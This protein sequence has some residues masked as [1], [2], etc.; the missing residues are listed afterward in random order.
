MTNA[1][2]IGVVFDTSYL[3]L[4]HQ[5][6][7]FA[8]GNLIFDLDSSAI[9]NGEWTFYVPIEVQSEVRSHF[10]S[11][12][13]SAARMARRSVAHLIETGCELPS[14]EGVRLFES[15]PELGADSNTDKRL[16]QFSIDLIDNGQLDF[17]LLATNDGGIEYDIASLKRNNISF[18]NQQNQQD[19]GGT[20]RALSAAKN[21]DT[22]PLGCFGTLSIAA[23]FLLVVA[24]IYALS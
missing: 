17:V 7:M 8:P 5:S 10:E 3:M 20:L 22:G 18:I 16:I 1:F 15:H 21:P 24:A 19:R 6:E 2:R 4:V 13:D 14:L 11:E 12:K 23:L 9:K